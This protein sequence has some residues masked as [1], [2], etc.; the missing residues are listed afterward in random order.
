MKSIMFAFEDSCTEE[1]RIY[2]YTC[3]N[4]PSPAFLYLK[5]TYINSYG[6]GQETG[7]SLL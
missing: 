4:S 6:S 2:L 5:F 1:A 7:E 3:Q